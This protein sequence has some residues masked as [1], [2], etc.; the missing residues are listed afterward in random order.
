[1][2]NFN[3]IY[4]NYKKII[5][6]ELENSCGKLSNSESN[7]ISSMRYSLLV[8][9]KRIR[10]VLALMVADF[11]GLDKSIVMPFALA[12]EHIHTYSLIHDDL[13]CMDN[14][15]FRRGKPTNHKVYGEDMA[16]LA[17]DGLLNKAFEILFD[18]VKD[19]SSLNA[20]KMIANCS[21]YQGMV[22]G[23]AYDI[24]ASEYNNS[25]ETLK[26]IHKNKTGKLI[27]ASVLVPSL[28]NGNK[29]YDNLEVYGENLG[30]LFQITDDL[31]DFS[32]TNSVLGKS[33]GKDLRDSK[34]TYV[35][36]LGIEEAE[37]MALE[38]YNKALIAI[39][40]LPNCEVL[41]SF[42]SFVLERKN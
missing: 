26:N 22:G 3:E 14:D 5:D 31:L 21:G 20:S 33:V 25:I 11:L 29:Y 37:K 1:M 12:I 24:K 38:V 13:P 35:T 32:S 2:K 6:L 4:E 23:Q 39:K 10:P 36:L 40:E 30:L 41:A 8:G 9:G 7:L 15:D 27:L 19:K 28:L 18:N 34:L 42:L 16:V 17:G